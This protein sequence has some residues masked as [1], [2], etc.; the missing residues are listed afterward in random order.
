MY[1]LKSIKKISTIL[2]FIKQ[3]NCPVC[4]SEEVSS[5][6]QV[7]EMM[8]GSR[9]MFSYSQCKICECLFLSQVPEDLGKYYPEN[10]Y[11]YNRRVAGNSSLIKRLQKRRDAEVLLDKNLKILSKWKK[12]SKYVNTLSELHL[13]VKSKVLDIGSGAGD[14][15]LPMVHA[16]IDIV[17]IDP[18]NKQDIDANGLKIFKKSLE[19]M[20]GSY[21][22]ITMNHVFEHLPDPNS[23]FKKLSELLVNDGRLMIRTPIIPN[24]LWDEYGTNWIQLDAPRHLII[25]SLKSIEMLANRYGFVFEKVIYDSTTFQF[26]GSEYYKRDIPMNEGDFALK[27]NRFFNNDEIQKF[28]KKTEELNNLKQSDQA[29]IILKRVINE[30]RTEK[31]ES[32]TAN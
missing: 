6:Y 27:N 28:V 12:S 1:I 32:I 15:M 11:S 25:H 19:E 2:K 20:S 9:E 31:T 22:V 7:K 4:Q 13:S 26:L 5:E 14:K 18:F 10:Y 24:A 21:D 23:T 3:M 8:L 16:G 17:G 29:A 30:E